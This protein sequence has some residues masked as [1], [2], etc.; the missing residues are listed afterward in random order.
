MN[1]YKYSKIAIN[2]NIHV[3]DS[4]PETCMHAY[5]HTVRT[6]Y[7]YIMYACMYI[8]TIMYKK[9]LH[10]TSFTML[11]VGDGE[12]NLNGNEWKSKAL[13]QW[14]GNSNTS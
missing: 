8:C 9:H 6:Y 14:Y 5:M 1:R 7:M 12:A 3:L 11:K 10:L 13:P 2:T 4:K